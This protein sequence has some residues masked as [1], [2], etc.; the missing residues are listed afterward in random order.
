M[1]FD[2][3]K[4]ADINISD[5]SGEHI[6]CSDSGKILPQSLSTAPDY[7]QLYPTLR[8]D[9][10]CDFCFNRGLPAGSDMKLDDLIR[11]TGLLKQP[12]TST[13]D[14]M[15]GEP[16]LHKDIIP[17]IEHAFS[18]GMKVNIS[19]NG[20]G[21]ERLSM[22]TDHFPELRVGISINDFD[23]L[24]SLSGM[25][26]KNRLVVKTVVGSQFKTALIDELMASGSGS[27]NLIYR[28][29]LDPA[30]LDD[31]MPFDIFLMTFRRTFDHSG[32]GTVFCS[33]FLP[34]TAHYPVLKKTRCPAGTTKL[35]I[36]P[37]GSAYPCNLF[38]GF[39]AFRLGNI[40]TTS[41]SEIW[42]HRTL[43][44]FR[45]YK[46]NSCPRTDCELHAE[47]HGG[48]PAH[49]FAHYGDLSA[50]EPRCTRK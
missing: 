21:R 27:V 29:A 20:K 43:D 9:L 41:F 11:M 34:D 23:M 24:G 40:F 2:K 6:L 50:P 48:C 19:T 33:G 47:C 37:D 4:E 10:A 46:R 13:I 44:Y 32:A 22:L 31:T 39:P 1:M 7:I 8:C 25:I 42:D 36:M 17:F 16:L 18:Q 30:H 45:V 49:S 5:S 38:F 35:G 28:D 3:R 14:I 15:G 12:G 26:F